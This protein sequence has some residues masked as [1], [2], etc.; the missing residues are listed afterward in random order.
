MSEW[1]A[2]PTVNK[3]TDSGWDA[4]PVASA[5]APS[6][7]DVSAIAAAQ[8]LPV[9]G[10][11]APKAAGYIRHLVKGG[12][13]AENQAQIEA[14]IAAYRQQH[15]VAS[16]VGDI[17]IGSLPYMAAGEFAGPAKLLGMTGRAA[18]AIPLGGASGAAIGAA[19][20]LARGEDP[21]HG[22]KMGAI[23]GAGGVA[24]GKAL[25]RV[26]DAARGMWVDRPR[27]PHTLDV[28]GQ[29]IPVRESVI[30]GD[31]A[32]SGA[33]QDMLGTQVPTAVQAEKDTQAAMQQAH[34]NLAQHLTPGPPGTPSLGAENAAI[35]DLVS[36][37]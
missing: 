12:T 25:G 7:Q 28:N 3:P 36:Q 27:I 6:G 15:P 13:T 26:W 33:E 17:A 37:G 2:F 19:D 14:D 5:P 24:G 29:P 10:A 31:P 35:G 22:A 21:V 4:F 20:A 8:A 11:Y 23:Y 18:T 34:Q 9:I 16:T 30:T 32:T 1:D